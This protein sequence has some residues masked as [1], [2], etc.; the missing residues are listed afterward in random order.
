[1]GEDLLTKEELTV[2]LNHPLLNTGHLCFVNKVHIQIY[3]R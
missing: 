1:M 3:S 2:T